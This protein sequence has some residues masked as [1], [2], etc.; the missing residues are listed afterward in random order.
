MKIAICITTRNRP[1]AFRK[2]I[3]AML[4]YW[5]V[6]IEDKDTECRLF[7]VD[8]ASYDDYYL[9][10]I[11]FPHGTIGFKFPERVGIPRAK[12]KCFELAYH[13]GAD[14]LFLFDDDCFPKA[15]NWHKPYIDSGMNHLC[16]TFT[17]GWDG[18]EGWG[19]P[20]QQG[21]FMIHQKGCGCMM[22]FTRKC[23]DVVGG[24]DTT[25]GLGKYEH[26]DLSRR[27]HNSGL[28]PYR[29]IDVVGSDKLFHSMDQAREVI[30]TFNEV[31]RRMLLNAG[32]DYYWKNE[33]SCEYKPFL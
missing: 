31:E 23:L 20:V 15:D 12:N 22:Y 2:C 24:F 30:R 14:H 26:V 11:M 16:F 6:H 10:G 21:S 13:W 17:E 1:D 28:T 29:F 19:S 9:E 25:F 8:D 7:I 18:T 27:I 32:E 33:N 4:K 5:P 3:M